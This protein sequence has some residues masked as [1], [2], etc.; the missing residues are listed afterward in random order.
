MPLTL[1]L[2]GPREARGGLPLLLQSCARVLRVAKP[3]GQAHSERSHR[4]WSEWGKVVAE[5]R[6]LASCPRY[7]RQ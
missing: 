1:C 2:R 6:R 4:M 5:V 3:S 7:V